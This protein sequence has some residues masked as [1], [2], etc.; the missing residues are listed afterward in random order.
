MKDF[1][2]YGKMALVALALFL[3]ACVLAIVLPVLKRAGNSLTKSRSIEKAALEVLKNEELKFLVTDRVGAQVV[4]ES[5]TGNPIL[6]GREGYLIGTARLYYGM[7]LSGLGESD[8]RLSGSVLTITLPQ[9]RELDFAADLDS[10]RFVSKRSGLM[11][12]AD[13]ALDRDQEAE[14]RRQF[15]TAAITSMRSEGMI[16]RKGDILAR[17]NGVAVR[18]GSALGVDVRFE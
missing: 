18:L 6:G 15:K 17:L 4:V 16:P 10:F 12:I 8:L 1:L 7:D 3:A 13:W 14:L 2:S 9:P 11:A 5:D